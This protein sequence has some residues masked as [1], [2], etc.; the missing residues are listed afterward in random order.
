MLQNKTR[1]HI[2][3]GVDPYLFEVTLIYEHGDSGIEFAF[4]KFRLRSLYLHSVV[5]I[6]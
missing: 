6:E 1:T 3:Y 2:S 5:Q 4:F